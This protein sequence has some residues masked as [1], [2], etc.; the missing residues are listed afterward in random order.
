MVDRHQSDPQPVDTSK[1]EGAGVSNQHPARDRAE[2]REL[3]PRGRRRSD[4]T[5]RG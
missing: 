4:S 1:P 5:R 3:P 2:Q